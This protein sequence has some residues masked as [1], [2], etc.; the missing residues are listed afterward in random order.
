MCV[1]PYLHSIIRLH[2]VDKFS[3]LGTSLSTGLPAVVLIVVLF[4]SLAGVQMKED[5]I[6]RA[7]NARAQNFSRK[8]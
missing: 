3:W 4:V 1:E 2:G 8:T 7:C 5:E 6:G